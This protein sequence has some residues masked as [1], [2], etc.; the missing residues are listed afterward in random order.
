MINNWNFNT[1]KSSF[2][3]YVSQMSVKYFI[4]K[5]YISFPQLIPNIIHKKKGST[6]ISSYLLFINLHLSS[7]L[8][9]FLFLLFFLQLFLL[10]HAILKLILIMDCYVDLQKF[11][12]PL[13]WDI[14]SLLLILYSV[15]V[16]QFSAIW[17]NLF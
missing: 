8:S 6:Y 4:H 9:N 1:L 5:F 16:S 12:F 14:L 15:H 7:F 11:F 2:D 10:H 17:K 3:I 13:F